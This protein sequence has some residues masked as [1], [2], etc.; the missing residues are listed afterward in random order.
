MSG[1]DSDY[2]NLSQVIAWVYLGD[3]SLVGEV[4][5]NTAQTRSAAVNLPDGRTEVVQSSAPRPPSLRIDLIASLR[6]AG[7]TAPVPRPLPQHDPS[8]F[9][10]AVP[11]PPS[12]RFISAFASRDDA[13]ADISRRLKDGTVRVSGRLRGQ[14]PRAIIPTLQL[15]DAAIDDDGNRIVAKDGEWWADLLI[16]RS[17]V[18]LFWPSQLAEEIGPTPATSFGSPISQ[19]Q[20][21]TTSVAPSPGVAQMLRKQHR[22]FGLDAVSPGLIL[23]KTRYAQLLEQLK[24]KPRHSGCSEAQFVMAVTRAW[25]IRKKQISEKDSIGGQYRAVM[26]A[27]ELKNPPLGYQY[28]VFRKTVHQVRGK[29][30]RIA[31]KTINCASPYPRQAK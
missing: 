22:R 21:S 9:E 5:D 4:G 14:G 18:L 26:R 12:N 17:V 2:W 6:G 27:L 1:F 31:R 19:S 13:E 30:S 3:R 28:E 10:P 7:T 15:L 29:R 16:E 24:L 25:L 23:L 20:S 8:G 11:S